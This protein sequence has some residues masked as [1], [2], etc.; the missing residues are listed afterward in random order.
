MLARTLYAV[1]ELSGFVM[2]CALIR[3]TGIEGIGAVEGRSLLD[4]EA[5]Y[6]LAA[7][8]LNKMSGETVR[9]AF[10]KLDDDVVFDIGYG[11]HHKRQV[12]PEQCDSF[13]RE[14]F[15]FMNSQPML[16]FL[17]G[18]TGIDALLPDPYFNGGGFH[19]TSRGGKLGVL[20]LA[21]EEGLGVTDP[22]LRVQHLDQIT[23]F[24]RPAEMKGA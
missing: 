23:R 17:E 21:P 5:A 14:F 6:L 16:Q 12:M 7:K 18:L 11:G 15:H 24:R 3:P 4:A 9:E 10:L 13:V 20:V 19:E 2:A 22:E 1:D 8:R